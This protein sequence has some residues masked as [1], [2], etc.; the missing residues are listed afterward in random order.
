MR[1]STFQS[2]AVGFFDGVHLGHQAIL[3]AADVAFT[4]RSHPLSVLCPE[5]APRLVMSLSSRIRALLATGVKE[6]IALEFTEE[7]ASM[8]PEDFLR[9]YLAPFKRIRCGAN[10]RFGKNGVGDAALA[11]SLGWDV[12]VCGYK[13]AGEE[14]ISST[15]IRNAISAARIKDANE[16]LGSSWFVTGRVITGKGLGRTIGLP[17]VNLAPVDLQLELPR[18]VYAVEVEG[19][20]AIANWGRAPTMRDNA[21]KENTLE[22]HFLSTP[23]PSSKILEIHFLDFIRE[24][25]VFP[26]LDA[27]KAQIKADI[28]R[29]Y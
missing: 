6:V 29:L 7:L 25:K 12:E 15:R 26:S 17:T 19:H 20:R 22:I 24:E 14:R 23:V 16:M 21:W 13:I 11:R 4:F 18:G 27:L 1:D 2:A 28:E 9:I 3:S 8:P 10:W 5:R